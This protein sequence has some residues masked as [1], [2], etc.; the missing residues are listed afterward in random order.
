MS[1]A[2][3]FHNGSYVRKVQVDESRIYDEVAY[4]L[5]ALT[6]N[7]VGNL[8]GFDDRGALR[9]YLQKFFVRDNEQSVNVFTKFFDTDFGISHTASALEVER[10]G[11]DCDGKNAHVFCQLRNDGSRAR[12]RAT[13]HTCGNEHEVV[14]FQNL[15]DF[16]NRFQRGIFADFRICAGAETSGQF[17]A[18]LNAKFCFA[19]VENLQVCVHCD[20]I[21]ALDTCVDHSVNGVI[22]ATANTDYS[23]F[24]NIY[25]CFKHNIYPPIFSSS[26]FM[27]PY[28]RC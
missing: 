22:S 8:E 16:V 24:C 10:F 13:A 20:E 15:F 17:F 26:F 11:N 7:V 4:A 2:L 1:E 25:R 3:V 21:R 27:N 14:S 6:E 18:E 23:D 12:T 9:N 5:N 19:S 28:F